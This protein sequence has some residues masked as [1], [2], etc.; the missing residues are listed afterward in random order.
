MLGRPPC[1]PS[2]SSPR[3]LDP[4]RDPSHILSKSHL[5]S[6]RQWGTPFVSCTH[7]DHIPF[8][9]Q[10][11][12]LSP[13]QSGS[14]K[15]SHKGIPGGLSWKHFIS[16]SGSYLAMPSGLNAMVLPLAIGQFRSLKGLQRGWDSSQ[17]VYEKGTQVAPR[18]VR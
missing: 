4:S 2:P 9:T 1:P 15:G 10:L 6:D 5:L 12:T 7:A 8:Q 3:T 11:L 13:M 14:R 18:M 17:P 16:L